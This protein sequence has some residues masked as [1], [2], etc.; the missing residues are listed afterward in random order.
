M[1]WNIREARLWLREVPNLARAPIGEFNVL[2]EDLHR[3]RFPQGSLFAEPWLAR[4]T[5]LSERGLLILDRAAGHVVLT[6][7]GEVLVEAIINTELGED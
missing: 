7:A 5:A 4:F 3:R 1:D 2:R 6:P